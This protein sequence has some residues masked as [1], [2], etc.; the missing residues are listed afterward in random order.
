MDKIKEGKY[1]ELAYEV[2]ILDPSDKSE[3]Q[4]FKFTA[5]HPD[6]FVFGMD[7]GML[8]NFS[9]HLVGL[10]KGDRFEFSLSPDEAFGPHDPELVMELD[11]EVFTVDGEFDAQRVFV[12]AHV[13]LQSEEGYRFDAIVT[14]IGDDKVTVDLN[15]ELAGETVGYRG[16]VLLVRDATAD[17]LTPKHHHCGCGCD[18]DHCD[19][20]HCDCGD[21]H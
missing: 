9:S 20:D 6:S 1:V 21:C 10:S 12:G 2:L 16:E 19:H 11:R 3:T 14:A 8:A 7:P 15:H 17:E 18:H 4:V 13:P 5:E